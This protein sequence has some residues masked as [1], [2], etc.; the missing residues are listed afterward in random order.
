[1]MY[2]LACLIFTAVI[3]VQILVVMVK[4]HNVYHHTIVWHPWHVS[5]NHKPWVHPSHVR[6]IGQSDKTQN[7]AIAAHKLA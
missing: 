5:E 4:F 3:G 1:M 6:E 7:L 2:W